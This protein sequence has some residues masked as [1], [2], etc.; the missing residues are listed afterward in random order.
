MTVNENCTVINRTSYV[1][2]KFYKYIIFGYL[3]EKNQLKKLHLNFLCEA[4]NKSVMQKKKETHPSRHK[5]CH[6][7]I[8]FAMNSCDNS[9]PRCNGGS[10][11]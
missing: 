3:Q 10:R 2:T 4:L 8:D 11:I 9:F 5:A 1:T 6:Q 7:T